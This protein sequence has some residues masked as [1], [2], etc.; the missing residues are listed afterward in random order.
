MLKW[1]RRLWP[2]AP[3]GRDQMQMY[4]WALF[5]DTKMVAKLLSAGTNPNV[6]VNEGFTPLHAAA[7]YGYTGTV[8]ALVAAG[9][10]PNARGANDAHTPLH[11]AALNGHTGTVRALVA[12]GA[13]PNARA[14]HGH[15]P[16]DY[17]AYKGHIETVLVLKAA[18][19]N[20]NAKSRFEQ[21]QKTLVTPYNIKMDLFVNIKFPSFLV[22][23][24]IPGYF[25]LNPVY[26][27]YLLKG[28]FFY[29]VKDS[30][31][32]KKTYMIEF[33]DLRKKM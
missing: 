10:D 8:K 32:P 26:H 21:T 16:L 33:P 30:H 11:A 7:G 2:S 27:W 4:V 12:A 9:A 24:L 1:L 6:K 13:D 20:L 31:N 17:A 23:L 22:A 15:T 18:G 29:P 14:S 25:I 5:G 28:R 19:A 3:A